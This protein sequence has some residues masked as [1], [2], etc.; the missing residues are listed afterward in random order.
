MNEAKRKYLTY[1]KELYAIVR[2]F[3][4]LETLPRGAEFILHSDHEALKFIQGQHKLNPLY[5]KWVEYLE[6]LNFMIHHKAGKLNKGADALLRRYFLL[7]ILESKVLGFEI[8]KEMYADDEDFKEI[9]AKC[10]SHPHDLFHI[11]DGFLFKGPQLCIPK[12]GFRELLIQELHGGALAGHFGVRENLL[13]AQGALL[14]AEDVQGCRTLC[15]EVFNMPNG[16]ERY[17]PAWS[18]LSFTRT[19]RTLGGH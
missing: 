8:V 14:L 10:A 1:D 9:Y 7:L 2:A 3:V 19:H 12:C 17:P 4:A 11:Q 16:Q 18:L 13:N 6:A 15:Q 5:G